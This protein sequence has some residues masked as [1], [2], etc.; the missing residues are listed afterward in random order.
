MACSVLVAASTALL[1][2]WCGKSVQ[3]S[4]TLYPFESHFWQR[5]HLKYHYLDE[6]Q[7]D[8]VVMVHGNPSWSFYY[9]ELVKA[10]R[11][12]YR[13]IVPDHIG[14]GYSDKPTDADYSYT[15]RQ[16][17]DD[18]EALLNH[19]NL[20]EN[21][22]IIAHDWGG[23]ISMAYAV[24]HP[25]RIKQ[26]VLFNTAAF[27]L[28]NNKPFPLPLWLVRNTA[29][30]ALGV[31]AFN[32]F[33]VGAAWIGTQR[34]R[35]PA[36][37]RKAYCAPYDSWRNRIATLRFVQDIPLKSSDPAYRIVAETGDK[38]HVLRD[39]PIMIV[40]GM[41]DFVFDEHFLQRWRK[42]FPNAEVH[43]LDDCG[44]YVLEDAYDE[45]IPLV[46]GFLT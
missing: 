4:E 20:H 14:C 25:E 3:V 28:P 41:K 34:K 46:K 27:P 29:I 37:L 30:G 10:L 42:E 31:R 22:T 35:M 33:A 26:I 5:G 21:I 36:E 44:H 24:Q 12:D 9:R 16:R 1:W 23:M 19:L 45:I 15:L 38:L 7:G 18:F 11:D 43:E 17:V 13:V 39:K 8:P 32:G 2:K 6:G 40:W